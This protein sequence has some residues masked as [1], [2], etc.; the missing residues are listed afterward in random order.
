[1]LRQIDPAGS[2]V[3]GVYRDSDDRHLAAEPVLEMVTISIEEKG[4]S[5]WIHVAAAGSDLDTEE[6]SRSRSV[7]VDKFDVPI[8]TD[9]AHGLLTPDLPGSTADDL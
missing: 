3:S 5:R 6:H 2:K 9:V 7:G 4:V 8:E 1:V